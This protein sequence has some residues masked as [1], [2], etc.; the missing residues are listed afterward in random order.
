MFNLLVIVLVSKKK[1]INTKNVLYFRMNDEKLVIGLL[2]ILQNDKV[3][4]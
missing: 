2:E 3:N 1:N 4:L